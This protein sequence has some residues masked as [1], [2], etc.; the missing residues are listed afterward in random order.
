[1][2]FWKHQL[3]DDAFP[4]YVL[5][6]PLDLGPELATPYTGPTNSGVSSNIIQRLHGR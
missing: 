6:E 5:N 3:L 1:M 4:D 2:K